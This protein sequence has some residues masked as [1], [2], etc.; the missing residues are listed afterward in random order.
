M[1]LRARTITTAVAF[2][3]LL[4]ATPA[5]LAQPVQADW[6][7]LGPGYWD[8]PAMWAWPGGGAPPEG[9]PHD[10]LGRLYDCRLMSL[11]DLAVVRTNIGVFDVILEQE[12][13]LIDD[14]T[15]TLTAL[16]DDALLPPGPPLW[17][18]NYPL[19]I[20]PDGLG[21]PLVTRQARRRGRCRGPGLC[22]DI[23]R[24]I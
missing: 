16:V 5:A 2:A 13:K 14:A 21:R 1:K 22:P 3:V 15:L 18:H 4:A 6:A 9:Y 24:F 7:G 11:G 10:T 23:W 20:G 17:P 19:A 12:L 8:D